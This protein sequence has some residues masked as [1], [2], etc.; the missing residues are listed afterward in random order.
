V[1]AEIVPYATATDVA[2]TPGNYPDFQTLI[3]VV[4][5]TI[6]VHPLLAVLVTDS[7]ICPMALLGLSNQHERHDRR[8]QPRQAYWPVEQFSSGLTGTL[9]ALAGC[10]SSPSETKSPSSRHRHRLEVRATL[11]SELMT[12]TAFVVELASDTDADSVNQPERRDELPS[13]SIAERHR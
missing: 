4:V 8:I 5:V 13:G 10:S 6:L 12:E 1:V 9:V 3:Q 2:K 11:S 7:T